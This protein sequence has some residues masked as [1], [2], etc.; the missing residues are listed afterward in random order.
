MMERT[1]T[2]LTLLPDKCV[3]IWSNQLD[4]TQEPGLFLNTLRS[5]W[6]NGE[7]D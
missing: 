1:P 6:I 4:V 7:S 5:E 2:E 3:L